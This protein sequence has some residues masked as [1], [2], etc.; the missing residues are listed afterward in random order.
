MGDAITSPQGQQIRHTS[1]QGR[2]SAE[3][4]RVRVDLAAFYRLVAHHGMTDLVLGHLSAR[5]PGTAD[6]FLLNPYPRMFE[7][8][9]ASSLVKVD[10][11]GNILLN[12]GS[13]YDIPAYTIHGAVYG[14][15]D[16]VGSAAHTH[17]AAGM[18]YSALPDAM[19]PLSPQGT[20]F[21]DALARHNFEGVFDN[22]EE[23][24]RLIADMGGID[25]ALLENHGYLV[26]AAGVPECWS[27]LYDL[28]QATLT[29]LA[30]LST[31]AEIIHRE[32]ALVSA[33]KARIDAE[34]QAFMAARWASQCRQLDILDP[35]YRD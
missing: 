5:V 22:P 11:D 4:W 16:D 25:A 34:S 19:L 29:H 13:N 27:L 33:D 31:G 28:E 6:Q 2:V 35:S 18:A 8:I 20:R 32:G 1:V 26:C 9:T 15:R 10:A 30:A 21:H 3:E 23:R 12:V 24:A 17:T 7:Q 14:A